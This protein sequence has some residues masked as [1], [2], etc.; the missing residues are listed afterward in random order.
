MRLHRIHACVAVAT[1]VV[2]AIQAPRLALANGVGENAVWQ[3][4]TSGDKVNQAAV[5]DMIQ[6]RAMGYYNAPVYTTNIDRQFNCNQSANATGSDGTQ[7][8]S[9]LSPSNS[10]AT[11]GATGNANSN[12]GGV[13]GS[14]SS[15]HQGNSGSVGSSTNGN[16]NTQVT[17]HSTQALNN[18]QH[19]SG[20]QSASV[21]GS[22][23]CSFGVLN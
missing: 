8:A 4:Q 1:L 3:F 14:R 2:G 16:T 19:N 17:G 9:A 18:N 11:S 5:Q 10:G 7:G 6:K 21:A 13:D 20:N 22:T 23:G 12:T 15:S